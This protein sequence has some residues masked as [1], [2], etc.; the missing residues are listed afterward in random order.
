MVGNGTGNAGDGNE[1]PPQG[2]DLRGLGGCLGCSYLGFLRCQNTSLTA[3]RS[4]IVA[5]CH[6]MLR[7]LAIGSLSSSM[8][9]MT[10]TLVVFHPAARAAA[11][12]RLMAVFTSA[13]VLLISSRLPPIRLSKQVKLVMASQSFLGVLVCGCAHHTS[14][15][16]RAGRII[17]CRGKLFSNRSGNRSGAGRC[18]F[19]HLRGDRR[20]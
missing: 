12:V 6:A 4:S 20:F 1:K 3:F 13:A 19:A 11:C 17:H 14:P 2:F 9:A 7:N 8:M 18:V 15:I 5:L 10:A 16:R